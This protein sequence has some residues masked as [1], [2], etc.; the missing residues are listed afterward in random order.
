MYY[1]SGDE[2]VVSMWILF[3]HDLLVHGSSI[4]LVL[5]EGMLRTLQIYTAVVPQRELYLEVMMMERM[6]SSKGTDE[7]IRVSNT[8]R[9]FSRPELCV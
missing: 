6:R 8:V 3:A 5:R 1:N 2:I 9:F 4:L 7:K